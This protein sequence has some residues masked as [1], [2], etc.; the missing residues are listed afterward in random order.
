MHSTI[1]LL[2]YLNKQGRSWLKQWWMPFCTKYCLLQENQE[3]NYSSKFFWKKPLLNKS[4]PDLHILNNFRH[5]EYSSLEQ[6]AQACGDLSILELCRRSS[7]DL[8][9]RTTMPLTKIVSSNK[10]LEQVSNKDPFLPFLLPFIHSP[11]CYVTRWGHLMKDGVFQMRVYNN[12]LSS[13]LPIPSKAFS[14][15]SI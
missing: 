7:S 6:D 1:S 15:P 5:F 8:W 4:S 13:H 14:I 10:L 11:P 9:Q 3:K 12:L 2:C